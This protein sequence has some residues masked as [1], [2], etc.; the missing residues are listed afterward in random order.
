MYLNSSGS[1]GLLLVILVTLICCCC[2]SGNAKAGNDKE[3]QELQELN[4]KDDNKVYECFDNLNLEDEHKTF[5]LI[6]KNKLWNEN[7]TIKENYINECVDRTKYGSLHNEADENYIIESCDDNKNN[8]ESE[9]SEIDT[10]VALGIQTT[11]KAIN[12]VYGVAYDVFSY[13]MSFVP[14]SNNTTT[15]TTTKPATQLSRTNPEAY[16]GTLNS[17]FGV[18]LNRETED[19]N[20]DNKRKEVKVYL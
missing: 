3:Y 18:V 9:K 17:K 12:L 15:T 14:S 4:D 8:N 13:S 6:I 7:I 5:D 19:K 11:K 16:L 20:D 2:C 10:Y 1:A